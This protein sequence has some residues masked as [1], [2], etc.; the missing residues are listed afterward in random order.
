MKVAMTISLLGLLLWGSPAAAA[1]LPSA[2]NASHTERI[3]NW[4]FL[5]MDLGSPWE[6]FRPVK[7]GKP[8]SVPLWTDVALPHCWNATDAVDPDCNYYEGPGWYRTLVDAA[9]PYADGHTLLHFGG[10]GQMAQVYVYTTLVAT[11]EGG[12]DAWDADITEAASRFLGDT[13]L[14]KRF[15][16]KVPVAVRCDNSRNT[17]TIPS[18][19]SDFCLYGGLYRHVELRKL[20]SRYIT[21]LQLR[22]DVKQQA[23]HATVYLNGASTGSL[24]VSVEDPSGRVVARLNA[25]ETGGADSVSL[26]IAVKKP[27]LWD[28][29]HP[30]LYRVTAVLTDGGQS[31]TVSAKTGF[32]TFE[33][34]EHGPFYLNGKRLLLRGTHRHEDHARLGAAMTDSLTRREMQMISDMGANFI[35]L[36]HYQQSD[37]VLDLCDSLGILVW[38]EEP[39]CRGGL[40]GQNYR[41]QAREMLTA[42]IRQ[43]YN[44]PSVILWGL[45][46]ENDWPGD[47]ASFDKDSIRLFMQQ[48]NDLAHRLDPTRLTT[49]RRCEFCSDVPDVYSPSIWAGWY[50][51]SMRDYRGMTEKAIARYP[52]FI[53]AEWGGD[54]H[55]GRHT[56]NDVST[57]VR[58]D[59]NGDW[60]ETYIVR[61]FDWTLHE[62][63]TMPNLTG[64]AF[65]TFKDFATPLRPTNPIPY[66]NQKGVVERDL[67]PKESYYVFQS[68]W[69]QKPM[70][71][72]YGHNWPVRWGDEGQKRQ[73]LVYSNCH[74]AE[75]FVNGV[76]QGVRSRD[77][78]AYPA[79]GLSWDVAYRPGH[80]TLRVV[81]DNGVVDEI[82]QDYE[83]RHWG[84]PSNVTITLKPQADGTT[85]VS[86]QLTD[87]N[88]V[89]C[90]DNSDWMEF[91][92]AGDA[93]LSDNQGTTTGSHKIQAS[94]GRARISVSHGK[95]EGVVAVSCRGITRTVKL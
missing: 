43:H 65:W 90:L 2:T 17:E 15:K 42:M 18:D 64:A 33:F 50:S 32:R 6:A 80:N 45:G 84:Q 67:T 34:K 81:A 87:A 7:A 9:N 66:V 85:L 76:S 46:N 28:T 40:G 93:T 72:I 30:D 63:A 55:A 57:V 20:P 79:C 89:P 88:G 60:S 11:H 94:N 49:L 73:V 35:R 56:E 22:P 19:M 26:K 24:S 59:A 54:S 58:G 86:A 16:G 23:I 10:T 70:A 8:E 37:L 13:V 91:S 29:T 61:L 47:F 78:K 21:R 14:Q 27:R 25:V 68:Y 3:V 62:Q 31:H 92:A 51:G 77:M 36:A 69:S 75:L 1:Q 53:H 48:Q 12:Y 82:E 4:Q 83:T 74:K 52:H 95:G 41:R 44:H 39:W 5:R 71:H 38:E